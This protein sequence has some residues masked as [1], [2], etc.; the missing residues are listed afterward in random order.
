MERL[1]FGQLCPP[2]VMC[3]V[4]LQVNCSRCAVPTSH[5]HQLLSGSSVNDLVSFGLPRK[6][7][8]ELSR[9]VDSIPDMEK[10]LELQVTQTSNRRSRSCFS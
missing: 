1:G 7:A 10:W 8:E 5:A 2:L 6:F 9:A 4:E 3:G